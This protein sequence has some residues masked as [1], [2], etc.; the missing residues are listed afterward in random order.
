MGQN[1]SPSRLNVNYRS[2]SRGYVYTTSFV[3]ILPALEGG[4]A[5]CYLTS[6]TASL[7][8]LGFVRSP[9]TQT[10]APILDKKIRW[11]LVPTAPYSNG[12]LQRP[13]VVQFAA[14]PPSRF[15]DK[16]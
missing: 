8:W 11:K 16:A 7:C 1:H 5:P 4:L 3:P 12:T 14:W 2:H 6:T 10:L 13:L 9:P 15:S